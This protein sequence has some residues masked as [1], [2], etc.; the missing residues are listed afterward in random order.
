MPPFL[1]HRW[2]DW[3]LPVALTTV[4]VLAALAYVHGWLRLRSVGS[5]A[6][7]GW[8]HAS[9]LLGLSLSW[10]AV[11]SPIA[12]CDADLLTFHMVQHLL[13]MSVAPPL[14][15]LGEPVMALQQ[16][17]P[18]RF[19]EWIRGSLFGSPAMRRIGGVLGNPAVCWLA[20]TATLVVWHVPSALTLGM[21]SETWHAIEQGSFFGSGIL[22][23]WPVVRPWPSAATEP[24][25]SIVLYLFLATLPCDILSGFLVFSERVAY[26]V[27]LSVPRHAGLAVV[28]DQAAAGAVMWM[29]VTIIYLVAGALV[30]LRLLTGRVVQPRTPQHIEA[31]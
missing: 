30:T 13:L 22:F 23:W 4:F 18:Q 27:Y 29:S 26:P 3:Q 20:A 2:D 1:Q 21:Q 28:E 8:R 12:S 19:A 10:I 17:I 15:L 6:A 25:W 9:F 16:A 31:V 11:A 5:P 24:Q 14:L 7:R